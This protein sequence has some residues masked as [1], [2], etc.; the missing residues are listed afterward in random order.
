[1]GNK[2]KMYVD[3][4]ACH[5]EVTGSC[6]LCVLKLPS[7]ETIK[8]IVDCGLF[9]GEDEYLKYNDYFPFDC[10]DIS[11]V[12]V[13]HNNVDHVGRLPMLVKNGF[14]GNIYTSIGT[15]TLLPFALFDSQ[16]VLAEIYKRQYKKALYSE[17]DVNKTLS[18]VV[19]VEFNQ[20]YEITPNISVKFLPNAHVV[21]AGMIN[22][23]ISYQDEEPIKLL[24]TG[25]YGTNNDFFD[26]PPIPQEIR[27]T[28]LS[29][30]MESTYGTTSEK[31]INYGYFKEKTAEAVE[32]QKT[33]IIPVLSLGRSQQILYELTKLQKSETLDRSIP[34]F[35]DGKLAHNYT[36]IYLDNNGL[37]KESMKDFLPENLT[38]VDSEMRQSLIITSDQKIIVTTSGMGTYGPAQIY[39]PYFI[40]QMNALIMF[41]CYTAKGTVGANLKEAKFGDVVKVNGILK[42]KIADVLYC[43]EFSS[44]AKQEELIS[45][46]QSFTNLRAVLINHGE[47]KVKEEFA[48]KVYN[49]VNA[50]DVAILNREYFFRIGS[51]GI[52]KTL[53]TKFK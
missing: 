53:T 8:F 49:E 18:Q 51:Y 50:S 7:R 32:K 35:F 36:R 22:I 41:T 43:T 33:I 12:L 44:H 16:K 45:F 46:L 30:V 31:D 42:R 13:T 24:F 4:M 15:K 48:E 11:F 40:S 52:E 17:A 27:D 26:V 29:I 25:D 1:M 6:F 10:N 19:G 23:E 2:L 34:I 21:G 39:L 20:K 47:T 37:I 38:F 9:Q 5:P 14:E 3:V 28:R